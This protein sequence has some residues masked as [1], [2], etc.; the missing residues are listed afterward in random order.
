MSYLEATTDFINDTSRNKISPS[1]LELSNIFKWYKK[2]FTEDGSLPDY[3]NPYT[4][5]TIEADAKI[6]FLEYDWSLNEI[7]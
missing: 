6:D 1:R 5:T 7:K 2:D 3:I 4:E